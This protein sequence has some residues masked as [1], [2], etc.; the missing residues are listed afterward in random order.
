MGSWR[1][2]HQHRPGLFPD[3]RRIAGATVT[4]LPI[5]RA[6]GFPAGAKLVIRVDNDGTWSAA[7]AAAGFDG[8]AGSAEP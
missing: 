4:V 5:G 3:V 1:D 7:I 8:V 6:I 2:G